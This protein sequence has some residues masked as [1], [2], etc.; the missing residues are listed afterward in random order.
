MLRCSRKK[1]QKRG[2]HLQSTHEVFSLLLQKKLIGL[3]LVQK[4]LD[5]RHTGLNVHSK[6]RVQTKSEAKRVGKYMIRHLLSLKLPFFD[7]TA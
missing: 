4:I 1:Q 2:E 3:P 5:W 6:V 7:E